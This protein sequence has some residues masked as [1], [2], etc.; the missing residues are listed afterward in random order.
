MGALNASQEEAE[1]GLCPLRQA[2]CC[3]TRMQ[4]GQSLEP[5]EEGG[6]FSISHTWSLALA[7]EAE[8]RPLASRTVREYVLREA[9]SHRK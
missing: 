6:R 7:S 1:V 4:S 8:F 3:V 5:W 2:G 9:P